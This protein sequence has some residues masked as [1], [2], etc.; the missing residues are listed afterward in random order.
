MKVKDVIVALERFAPLPLQDGYDNAGLQVGL[1][2]AEVSGA[3][4][5]LDVTEEVLD[6]AVRLGCNL[7]VAHHPLMFHPLRQL[8]DATSVERCVRFAVNNDISIYAAHTNLDN[9]FGGVSFEM[10]NHLG[11]TAIEFLQP[12]SADSGSGVVGFFVEPMSPA[13]FIQRLKQVFGVECVQ[14]NQM[15]SRPISKVALCGGSGD[16][17][18]PQAIAMRADAFVTG[19]MHYHQYFGHE[20]QLQIAV[21]GHYQSEQYTIQLL[22]R[23][24]AHD[25]PSLPVCLTSLNTNPIHYI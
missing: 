8:T 19:E 22:Q 17:L 3:L 6:E 11:L 14:C 13:D 12:Q 21:L 2:E 1:T 23:I 24:L 9:A 7:V 10:A 15:L 16:F 18:L 5:C 4:L 20:Q 25:L